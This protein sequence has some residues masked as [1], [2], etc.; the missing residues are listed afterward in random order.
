MQLSKNLS[1]AE[2]V[3]SESAKRRNIKNTPTKEHLANLVSIA[4][5]VFQ[6]IRDHFLVPIH[7][8]SGYR[9][10]ALN[11]AVGG[12]NTS[13]HSK[14]Q[15][16]D[17]DMDGTK[18]TNKQIFNFIKDNIEFD[19]LIWEFGTDKNPDWVHV[20][21]AKGKNRKQILK[22]VRRNGKTSYINF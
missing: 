1:L 22:A 11:K 18:I 16:L 15:A 2:I 4:L 10:L 6:P 13:Q 7:I 5:N 3:R 14:G 17:I 20:S 8:S 21:Y 9:S 19:Q 12:S